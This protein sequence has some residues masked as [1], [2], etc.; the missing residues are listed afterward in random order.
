MNATL[1]TMARALFQSWFV[2]FDPVYA[3]AEGRPRWPRR[4]HRRPLPAKFQDSEFGEIPEGWRETSIDEIAEINGWT[5]SKA[6]QTRH[7]R[8]RRNLR[9]ER[10]EHCQRRDL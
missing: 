8:I 3:K 4:T 10:W 5:L 9:S 7:A 2:D 1:E 6:D